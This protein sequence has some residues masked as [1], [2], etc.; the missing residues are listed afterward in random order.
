[1]EISSLSKRNSVI[2]SKRQVKKKLKFIFFSL[3]KSTRKCQMSM[4]MV[5]NESQ[6]TPGPSCKNTAPAVAEQPP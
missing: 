4:E 1:M 3:A 6:Q 5:L 2:T